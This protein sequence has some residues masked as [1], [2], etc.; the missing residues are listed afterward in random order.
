[1]HAFGSPFT[2]IFV[3]GISILLITLIALYSKRVWVTLIKALCI[4]L[5]VKLS[6]SPHSPITAY[7]AVS[8]QAIFGALIFSLFS[9]RAIPILLL[10]TVTF[11]ESAM[12]KLLVLTILYGTSFWDAIDVYGTWVSE[13]LAFLPIVIS[14]FLPFL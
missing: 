5:L 7:V 4:V 11:L 13:K 8:F 2:G 9:V 10:G 1:M 3:G 12:Q 14:S 6:V